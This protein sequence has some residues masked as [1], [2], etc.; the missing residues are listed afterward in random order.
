MISVEYVTKK[1]QNKYVHSIFI[2]II[3]KIKQELVNRK[4]TINVET[5]RK[6]PRDKS[7]YIQSVVLTIVYNRDLIYVNTNT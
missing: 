1:Y 5:K 2:P 6:K 3:R 4:K 7:R